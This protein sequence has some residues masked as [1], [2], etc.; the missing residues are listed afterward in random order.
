MAKKDIGDEEKARKNLEGWLREKLPDAESLTL[1][2]I[3]FPEASGESSVTLLLTAT[4]KGEEIRLVCRMEPPVSDVFDEYEIELQYQLMEVMQKHGVPVPPLLA[5][6]PDDSLLGSDFYVMYF[7]DGQIPTDNPPYAFGSWVT[8]LSESERSTMWANGIETLAK[9]HQI[10]VSE[11]D[12]ISK[13]PRPEP[14]TSPIQH[15]VNKTEALFDMDTIEDVAP[16]LLEGLRYIQDNMPTDTPLRLCWGDSRPGNVIWDNLK[17]A[18][19]IDWEMAN[20]SDPLI[21]VSWWYWI[22]YINSVGLG[23]ERPSGLPTRPE[24]YKRWNEL[25]GLPT[26]N[27]LLYDLFNVVRYGVILERKFKAMVE[28]GMDRI[29]NFTEP[30]AKELLAELKGKA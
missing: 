29:P 14:G 3:A 24:L 4:N 23:A 16:A 5:Y 21:D 2:P 25:T 26:D 30:F 11:Y 7:T 28:M 20:I 1:A 13:L 27:S 6:E 12:H 8:E 9:I 15:E 22:D 17:P 19:V 18:A 10:D